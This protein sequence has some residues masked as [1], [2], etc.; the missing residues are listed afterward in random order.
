MSKTRIDATGSR[1]R[2]KDGERLCPK[3]WLGSTT[4][5]GFAREVAAW[6]R[7]VDPKHEVGKLIQRITKGT[8]RATEA[9][10]DG[11]HAE[12]DK[13][14]ELD[15]EL[16]VALANATEGSSKVHSLEGHSSGAKSGMASKGRRLC[17]QVIE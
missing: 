5:G 15:Y 9:R 16:A 3:S 13:Y 11:R 7:Y 4:L 12:D 17:A 6:L 1:L 8:L 2:L 14:D 10:T